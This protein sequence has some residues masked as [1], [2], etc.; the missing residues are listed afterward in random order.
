ML[1]FDLVVTAAGILDDVLVYL[2]F[3]CD[4]FSHSVTLFLLL[5]DVENTV[6]IVKLHSG[7][8]GNRKMLN[9]SLF[10]R[11]KQLPEDSGN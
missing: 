5:R 2:S 9:E 4:L 8:S 1:G 10:F 7:I 3:F 11:A 6:N